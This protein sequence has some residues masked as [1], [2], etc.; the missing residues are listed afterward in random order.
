MNICRSGASNY[1]KAIS[2][3]KDSIILKMGF[4]QLQLFILLI[5]VALS[6]SLSLSIYIYIYSVCV[7]VC[8]VGYRSIVRSAVFV[9]CRVKDCMLYFFVYLLCMPN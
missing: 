5:I 8:G 6:L 7:C 9:M 1:V 3:M 2:N 4:S